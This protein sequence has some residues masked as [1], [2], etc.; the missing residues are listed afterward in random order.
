MSWSQFDN[1]GALK[2]SIV[3]STY[4]I[5]S[6]SSNTAVNTGDY[7]IFLLTTTATAPFTI[8]LPPAASN[9]GQQITVYDRQ[10]NANNRNVTVAVTSGDYLDDALN[11]TYVI[12][13]PREA[14]TI[15]SDG[16][17]WYMI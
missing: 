10:G 5:R 7:Y 15:V 6:V 14:L 16:S 13:V 12:N 17:R 9:A 1:T 11:G 2:E 8:T 3:A 4:P